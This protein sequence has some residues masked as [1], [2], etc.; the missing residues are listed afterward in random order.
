MVHGES[1]CLNVSIFFLYLNI[2]ETV[3]PLSQPVVVFLYGG[4]FI[5]GGNAYSFYDGRYLSAHGDVVVVV[6]NYRLNVFGF[7]SSELPDVSGNAGLHDILLCLSWVK[8]HITNFGGDPNKVLLFGQGSGA[9]GAS[10]V[11]LSP[12]AEGLVRRYFIQGGSGYWPPPHK[13]KNDTED[14]RTLARKLLCDTPE[15]SATV[16]CLRGRTAAEILR[17]YN[18]NEIAFY[19]KTDKRL[20]PFDV[21]DFIAKGHLRK[22]EFLVGNVA[23]E[24]SIFV[25]YF[26]RRMRAI[27]AE[28]HLL[29]SLIMKT[30]D[31]YF[32]RYGLPKASVIEM[33]LKYAEALNGT[34]RE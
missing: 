1:F 23:S 25:E 22:T 12:R 14:L 26:A 34:T 20:L 8:A 28:D 5:N 2:S 4:L 21:N 30:L 10:Y 13:D 15:V 29:D 27:H 17:Q 3:V 24:E 6:P 7:L 11:Y 19:P 18:P 33:Y 32:A 9:V 16:A 31:Y